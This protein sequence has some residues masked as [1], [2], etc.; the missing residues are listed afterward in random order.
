MIDTS[1]TA[2]F[3][4]R[5][6]IKSGWL[7]RQAQDTEFI[8]VQYQPLPTGRQAE[9]STQAQAEGHTSASDRG[10]ERVDFTGN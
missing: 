2:N 8:E 6:G 10:V 3:F 1:A 7:L 5:G 4:F 9:P